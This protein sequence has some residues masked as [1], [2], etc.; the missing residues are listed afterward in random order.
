MALISIWIPLLITVVAIVLMFLLG[1]SMIG[2]TLIPYLIIG[3]LVVWAAY[4]GVKFIEGLIAYLVANTL[5]LALIG[6][7][8]FVIFMMRRSRPTVVHYQ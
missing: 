8:I 6:A 5:Y 2:I 3:T 7:V 4:F 1:S